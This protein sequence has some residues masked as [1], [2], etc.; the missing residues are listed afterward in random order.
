[1]RFLIGEVAIE[2]AGGSRGR[3]PLVGCV[4]G[5]DEAVV[6][7]DDLADDRESQAASGTTAGVRSALEA[8]KYVGEISGVDP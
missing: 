3:S 4:S 5:G 8:V 1:M 6:L 7:L 2:P